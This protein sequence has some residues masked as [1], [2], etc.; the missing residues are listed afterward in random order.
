MCIRDRLWH[1]PLT[2]GNPCTEAASQGLQCFRTERMTLHG[3]RQ[4]DRPAW[5]TLHLP[6]GTA[7]AL[8]TGLDAD[9][10][11]LQADGQRWRV[12]LPLL[13]TVWRGQYATVWR[14]PPGHQGRI[15]N[16]SSGPAAQWMDE[17]LQ[18]LQA[19][20]QL[21]AGANGFAQRLQAF[22]QT[23]GIEGH[24]KATPMT[25]MQVNRLVGVDEPRLSAP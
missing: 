23:Q 21:P 18:Q 15:G 7:R 10:A 9:S 8:L 11:T 3:L 20:G 2:T 5:L 22:Q 1:A 12:P 19:K 13:Q 25:F 6:D 4:L 17:Q 14:R 24:G 16:V